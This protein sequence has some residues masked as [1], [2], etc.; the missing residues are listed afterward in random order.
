[1]RQI[2]KELASGEY[3]LKEQE[4]Q[5][6]RRERKEVIAQIVLHQ[7]LMCH[8]DVHCCWSHDWLV[9]QVDGSCVFTVA[10]P[11]GTG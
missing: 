4:R 8:S 1:M 2:D 10:L 7:S 9:V 6:R 11:G 3:F 5:A